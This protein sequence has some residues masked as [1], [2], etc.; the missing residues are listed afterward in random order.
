MCE[1]KIIPVIESELEKLK[2][3]S[4]KTFQETFS[5]QNTDDNMNE[6][7]KLNMNSCKLL[8]ELK[9]PNTEFYF[10]YNKSSLLGYL[11]LNYKDAQ[12]ENVLENKA[13]EI[14][15][16]YLLKT[17]KN[18]GYG[19]Q[20]FKKIVSIGKLKGY[21]RLWLGV[22]E[23]NLP[24]IKFYNK[25]KLKIFDKHDFILGNDIQTDFLMKFDF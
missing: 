4:I 21:R 12:T 22:W 1:L 2:D 14:E 8:N 9:N 10:V 24:A 6:Y 11:K 20:L 7:L 15:R 5:D 16:I 23:H 25:L 18:M 13:F 17:F 19:K 3:L